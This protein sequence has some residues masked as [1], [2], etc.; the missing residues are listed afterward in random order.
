[1]NI[2][3]SAPGRKKLHGAPRHKKLMRRRKESA[4]VQRASEWRADGPALNLKIKHLRELAISLLDELGELGNSRRVRV[5]EGI[6]LYAEVCRFETELIRCA[7][8]HT[9]GH[10]VR[11]ARLLGLKTT[12]LNNKIKQYKIAIHKASAAAPGRSRRRPPVKGQSDPRKL[13][14]AANP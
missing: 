5:E 1:L 6:D 3:K 11:A 8:Q 2:F 13:A 7:L 12:T 14:P 4:A 10:Q 9:G